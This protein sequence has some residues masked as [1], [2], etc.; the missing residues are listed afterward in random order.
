MD[1]LRRHKIDLII[2]AVALLARLLLFA[3]DLHASQGNLIN[4][5]HGDDGYYELSRN[6]VAGHGFTG[7]STPPY[8]PNPLRTPGYIFFLA[9]LLWVSKSYWVVILVQ[10]V[11]GAFVPLLGRRIA[12]KLI[13]DERI[14][15]WVGILMA[16]DPYSA[17]FSTIFYT[18]TFFVFLFLWF[19]LATFSYL[20]NGTYRQLVLSGVLLGVATL[21][22]PTVQ[23]LPIVVAP[24]F[25]YRF[26]NKFKLKDNL[27]RIGVFLLL[28]MAMISP[29]LYR[30][31][32]TFGVIGLSAQPAYNVYVYL[33]PSILALEHGTSFGVEL[34]EWATHGEASGSMI[35]LANSKMYIDEAL[36]TIEAHPFILL[37]L[38]GISFVTFFTHDGMLTLLQHA[39]IVPSA[40]L[41][42]PILSLLFRHPYTL[43]TATLHFIDT[44]FVLIPLVRLFWVAV[45]VLFFLGSWAFVKKN[46]F[47]SK[48]ILSLLLVLYFLAT[49]A[50][51]GLGV[52]ARYR[53]PITVILFTFAL[54]FLFRNRM[55][56]PTVRPS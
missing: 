24:F 38:V 13:P 54:Y 28:Y 47:D 22:K 41:S 7:Q 17:L 30:N 11:M 15:F 29:W 26:R 35:T 9:G 2:F 55:N 31:L 45:T 49:T 10:I 56:A 21:T 3:I 44:P 42:Q 37:A 20:E 50:I 53:M 34:S 16:L 33:A 36:P 52:N 14:G 25:F 43:L 5:I 51:I 27:T 12:L 39:G 19:I 4:A 6:F 1:F 48:T 46:G 32:E 23:Y 8:I 18:E 40:Y